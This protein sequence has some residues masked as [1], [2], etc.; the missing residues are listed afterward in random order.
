M[1][2]PQTVPL[3]QTSEFPERRRPLAF[4]PFEHTHLAMMATI[5]GGSGAMWTLLTQIGSQANQR[6]LD[7]T[8][9][10]WVL[11]LSSDLA[12]IACASRHAINEQI[13]RALDKGR[14]GGVALIERMDRREAIA[15]GL[16]TQEEADSEPDAFLYRLLLENLAAAEAYVRA[17]WEANKENEA[18][19]D[20]SGPP[21]EKATGHAN[22]EWL[23]A[24]VQPGEVHQVNLGRSGRRAWAS[25][26][27]V[28]FTSAFDQ[29]AR[30]E[31][32]VHDGVFQVTAMPA[33]AVSESPN[34]SGK[35]IYRNPQPD[36][37]IHVSSELR[38]Y[39]QGRMLEVCRQKAEVEL[40]RQI[41]AALGRCP[42]HGEYSYEAKLDR[43]IS[44]LMRKR[45]PVEPGIF[46]WAAG[47]AA[48]TWAEHEEHLEHRRKEAMERRAEHLRIFAAEKRRE[49][50]SMLGFWESDRKGAEAVLPEDMLAWAKRVLSGD[51]Q[52][53]ADPGLEA[54]LK[55]RQP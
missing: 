40:L 49:A 39:V 45:K 13:R 15:A 18:A 11:L 34:G 5:C 10:G 17:Q 37:C 44:D 9:T 52:P 41:A 2:P 7:G 28:E 26:G 36:E 51:W 20:A 16:I 48:E 30:V 23:P 55:A 22:V 12:D 50:K 4:A 6:H 42:V 54:W 53:E 43:T 29:P 1:T 21:Q 8:V 38:Q 24:E 25:C 31:M 47:K 3:E 27:Q 46:A 14:W 33:A 32:R 19:E 35:Y